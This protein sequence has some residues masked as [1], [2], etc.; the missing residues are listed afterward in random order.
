MSYAKSIM[1]AAYI[2]GRVGRDATVGLTL[3]KV[4]AGE[5]DGRVRPDDV[6]TRA[7]VLALLD[8]APPRFRAAVAL[9]VTGLRIG[10]VMGGP[11]P[12]RSWPLWSRPP[13]RAPGGCLVSQL[14]RV[15]R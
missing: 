1:K 10:E 15:E 7:E 5:P 6:P 12:T 8:G 13:W 4:R 9:G 11:R 2:N 14:K 3:P